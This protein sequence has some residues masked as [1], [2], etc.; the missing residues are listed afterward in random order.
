MEHHLTI[1]LFI[2]SFRKV[3][4]NQGQCQ[5]HGDFQ[6]PEGQKGCPQGC[7]EDWP[8]KSQDHCEVPSTQNSK[9]EKEP[10]IPSS[11]CTSG[12]QA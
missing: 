7:P 5:E 12:K 10:Q 8:Q 3:Q 1:H 6:G 11:L 4:G 9:P 2:H